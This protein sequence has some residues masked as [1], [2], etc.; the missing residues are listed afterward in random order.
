MKQVDR[1][2]RAVVVSA[3][4]LVVACQP[5]V[6]PATT[7]AV[8]AERPHCSFR[9][10]ESATPDPLQNQLG[11][12]PIYRN[13]NGERG[14]DNGIGSFCP[15]SPANR[16]LLHNS[17]KHGYLAGYCQSCLGVPAGKLFVFWKLFDQPSCPSGC[18]PGA[19]PL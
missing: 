16:K 3:F 12:G 11:C 8:C 19:P 14:G 1:A 2:A 5:A 15:D 6:P 4:G 13:E 9:L 7:M 18:A 17:A 10:D